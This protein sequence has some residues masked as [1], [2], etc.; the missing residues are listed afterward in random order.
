MLYIYYACEFI[1][2]PWRKVLEQNKFRQEKQFDGRYAKQKS[3]ETCARGNTKKREQA[4]G[5]SGEKHFER[6]EKLITSHSAQTISS[7]LSHRWTGTEKQ[8]KAIKDAAR[9]MLNRKAMQISRIPL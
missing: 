8:W 9:K 6:D 7:K 5:S 4:S 1:E 2:N 3:T